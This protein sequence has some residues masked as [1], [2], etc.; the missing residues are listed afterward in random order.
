M[1]STP[2]ASTSISFNIKFTAGLRGFL[3][4]SLN[5]SEISSFC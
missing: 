3:P 4:A 1:G 5:L 2:V